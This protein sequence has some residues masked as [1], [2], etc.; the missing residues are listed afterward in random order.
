MTDAIEAELR[1]SAETIS[2]IDPAQIRRAADILVEAFRS[3][4]QAIFMGNG[5]SS[6]DAQHIA[7]EF[8][9][10]YMIDRPALPGVCLSNIAPV[11]AIGNDYS[12]DLVFKRQVE[13][14]CREGDVVIGMS[15]SGNSKNVILAME[16]AK[17]RGAI[18]MSFTGDGGRLREIVDMAVV[19]PSKETPRI[20]E[21]YLC[22]CHTICGIVERELFG[23]RAVLVD[24]DDTLAP[25]VPYCSDPDLFEIY[26]YVPEAVRRL[27]EAGYLVIVVTNQSGIGRGY[28]DEATLGRIHD[29]L[30]ASV[31]AGGGRIDD[32]IFCPHTPEDR[33][34]CRKPE[35]GMGLEAIAR[36]GIDPSRSF[37]VG[38]HEKDMEFARRLGCTGIRV[39]GDFT[40]ADAVDRILGAD[41]LERR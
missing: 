14:F 21:G 40:F 37:M 30:R 1:R 24:R 31:E 12:Y 15:T 33:C 19:I 17:E 27:N 8:S 35:P 34:S 28:F 9:G 22:A 6:A 26:D 4:H 11:T 3:G 25:D 38:D 20:Q 29:K 18:T 23:R 13:A 10:R 7:A 39:S 32:I 16:A 5:G 36:H 2:R 41:S